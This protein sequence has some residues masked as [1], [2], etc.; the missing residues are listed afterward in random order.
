[1]LYIYKNQFIVDNSLNLV[2]KNN[3]CSLKN[4]KTGLNL[5]LLSTIFIFLNKFIAELITI[6]NSY[7]F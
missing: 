4:K 3:T 5:Q 2:S 7:R 6:H 1:M